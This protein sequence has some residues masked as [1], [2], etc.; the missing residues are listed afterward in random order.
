MDAMVRLPS[1]CSR[2]SVDDD[3]KRLALLHDVG[4]ELRRIAAADVPD[5]VDRLGRDEQD[6]TGA[7]RPWLLTV[8]LVLERPF[9]NVD[10]LLARMLVSHERRF[11][12]D[13]D[14]VLNDLSSRCAQ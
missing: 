12:A 8:D 2:T 7:V 9:E 10:D 5:G 4:C 13:V 1:C 14:T 6:L 3:K 11:R